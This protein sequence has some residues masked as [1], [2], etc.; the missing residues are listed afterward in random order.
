[1]GASEEQAG[2][3]KVKD[4]ER[5]EERELA[6]TELIANADEIFAI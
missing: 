1:M 5:H 2:I 4:L 6:Y 3:V